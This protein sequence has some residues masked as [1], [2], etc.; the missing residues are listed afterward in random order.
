VVRRQAFRSIRKRLVPIAAVQGVE[1]AGWH[2][3]RSSFK[4]PP[5][6]TYFIME[7]GVCV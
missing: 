1:K 3:G 7:M 4:G 5:P 6:V 2:Q